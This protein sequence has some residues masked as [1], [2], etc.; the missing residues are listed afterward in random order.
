MIQLE[1]VAR[2]YRA[3]GGQAERVL[4][5]VHL[6]IANGEMV[7]LTGPSGAG[8]STL[9]NILSCLDPPSDGRYLLDGVDVAG[10]SRRRLA[11][12]RGQTMSF[13]LGSFDLI[14]DL[15][16]QRNVELPLVYTRTP[17][18]RQRAR[19][20][21]DRVGLSGHYEQKPVELSGAQRQK[22]IIARALI[23][24]P[25]ILL[26]DEPTRDLDA[27]SAGEIMRLLEE[28]NEA[29]LTVIFCTHEEQIATYAKRVVRLRGGRIVSDRENPTPTHRPHRPDPPN[30]RVV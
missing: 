5:D 30:L 25:E 26:D 27:V 12:L 22:A 23:N 6:T 15:S 14:S 4:Q 13:V 7:A 18:R 16:L 17:V 11:K 10:L 2:T 21:L 29:G 20:A 1:G 28:L 9:M 8:T 24:D 19:Q 3:R